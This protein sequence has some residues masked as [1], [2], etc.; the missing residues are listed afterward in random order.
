MGAASDRK[1]SKMKMLYS[2]FQN[3]TVDSVNSNIVTPLV[4]K[5]SCVYHT[6]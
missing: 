2:P 4:K 1:T 6:Y 3:K 5:Q